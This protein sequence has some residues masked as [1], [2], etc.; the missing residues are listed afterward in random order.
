MG[1][2][3][4]GLRVNVGDAGERPQQPGGS[5]GLEMEPGVSI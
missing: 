5:R 1:N 2:A 3:F 4:K